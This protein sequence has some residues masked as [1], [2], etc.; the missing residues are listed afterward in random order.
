MVRPE[1][2]TTPISFDRPKRKARKQTPSS[3]HRPSPTQHDFVEGTPSDDWWAT[4]MRAEES[5]GRMFPLLL[6]HP[7]DFIMMLP[8]RALTINVKWT[9]RMDGGGRPSASLLVPDRNLPADLYALMMGGPVEGEEQFQFVGWCYDGEL[10]DP[11]GRAVACRARRIERL[12][13]PREFLNLYSGI[14]ESRDEDE[15]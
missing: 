9:P 10:V 1:F 13:T 6:A 12:R 14:D 15:V 4:G 8:D 3:P 2:P 7:M 11:V 5:F